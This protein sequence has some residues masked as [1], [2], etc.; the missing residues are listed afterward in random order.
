[1]ELGL[2][3]FDRR[4]FVAGLGGLLTGWAA[5]PARGQSSLNLANRG[6][7]LTAIAKMRGSTN[8]DLVMGWVIGAR[9]AVVDHQATPMFGILA[10]TFSRYRQISD[11]AY[12]AQALELAYFTDLATGRLL[13]TWKNPITGVTVEVP[14]IRMGPS[15][16]VMTADG[17]TVTTAAGEAVGMA[18]RHRFRPAVTHGDHVW[19]TEEINVTG[20]RGGPDAKPFAYNEMSTYHAR[21]SDL[22]DPALAAVPTDVQFHSLVTWRPWMGFGDVPGHTTARAAGRRAAQIADFPAYYVKLCE[23]H[24]PDV[25]KDPLGSLDAEA[26]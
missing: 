17:L 10:G 2:R 4:G 25:M 16:F 6:D 13:E 14:M 8:D 12:E 24:H 21:R 3:M 1:M 26:S 20:S 9:Y 18:L 23:R 5:L 19:I 7:F 22:A 11:R 15:R